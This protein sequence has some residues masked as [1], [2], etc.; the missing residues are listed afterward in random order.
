MKADDA[1]VV[2]ENEL[3]NLTSL[4]FSLDKQ[5]PDWQP[6]PQYSIVS[7][8]KPLYIY[9]YI[10]I[11]QK[12]KYITQSINQFIENVILYFSHYHLKS[13]IGDIL[14]FPILL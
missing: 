9:I 14:L 1:L 3:F 8:Q 10:Y 4:I 5:S 6:N 13:N 11:K 12:Y 7:P 2:E